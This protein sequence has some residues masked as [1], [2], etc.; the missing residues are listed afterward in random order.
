MSAPAPRPVDPTHVVVPGTGAEA[1]AAAEARAT[2]AA[3]DAVLDHADVLEVWVDLAAIASDHPAVA[4]AFEGALERAIGGD[5]GDAPSASDGAGPLRG[6]T[7][8]ARESLRELLALS[9]YHRFVSLERLD[10][11]VNGRRV[12]TY[13]PDHG[14]FRIDADASPDR[15][16]LLEDVRAALA[17]ERAGL[18][19]A[20][21]LATWR[22][23]GARY[24]LEP[25]SLCVND[26]TCFGL[27]KLE[28]V[29]LAPADRVVELE[30]ATGDGLA[31]RLLDAVGASRPE[32]FDLE[33][34]TDYEAV[35]AGLRTV[36]DALDVPVE[37]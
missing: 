25:P 24:A 7:E 32:R 22:A 10:A 14:Q 17:G 2:A 26:R 21:T 19:P 28:G 9:S 13:V 15:D 11:S 33:S 23:S 8:V 6:R 3:V 27:S 30:W 31:S 12:M 4:N 37:T 16:A 18:L 5:D 20:R 29:V 1:D 35:A 36:A 34:Q